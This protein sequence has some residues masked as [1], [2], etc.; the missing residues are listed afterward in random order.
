MTVRLTRAT[1]SFLKYIWDLK[2][3]VRNH[4]DRVNIR[5]PKAL[6]EES[7]LVICLAFAIN[8]SWPILLIG[9]PPLAALLSM[10]HEKMEGGAMGL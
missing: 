1:S 2:Q 8:R 9:W 4:V 6:H 5:A 3:I 7:V 10:H